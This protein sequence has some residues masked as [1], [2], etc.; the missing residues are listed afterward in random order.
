MAIKG[1]SSGCDEVVIVANTVADVNYK[2]KLIEANDML[3]KEIDVYNT[4]RT[5]VCHSGH[6]IRYGKL[7]S[8]DNLCGC[9]L[10]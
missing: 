4:P 9:Q 2:G 6:S 5:F 10:T 7:L 8:G 3:Q 1:G